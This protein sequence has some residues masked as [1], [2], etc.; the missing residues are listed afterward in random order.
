M[1]TSP[2]TLQCTGPCFSMLSSLSECK[3]RMFTLVLA[4][5][6]PEKTTPP[7][8]V[9]ATG[10][11]PPP[12]APGLSFPPAQDGPPSRGEQSTSPL[13]MHHVWGKP[14]STLTPSAVSREPGPPFL[15]VS[16][17]VQLICIFIGCSLVRGARGCVCDTRLKKYCILPIPPVPHPLAEDSQVSL[18]PSQKMLP[19][20][21]L[22]LF[23]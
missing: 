19:Y 16:F 1:A 22:S 4:Y 23:D 14:R 6:S 10:R 17:P 2:L 13:P 9:N 15:L 12:P 18:W 8:H 7:L 3:Y 11:L 21:H 20:C 5:V